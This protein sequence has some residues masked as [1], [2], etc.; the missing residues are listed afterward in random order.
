[1]P[2]RGKRCEPA[3]VVHTARVVADLRAVSL[4]VFGR[5]TLAN[6]ERRFGKSFARQPDR[7]AEVASETG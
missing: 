4:E 1:V 5:A 3:F 2:L 7:T 6:T